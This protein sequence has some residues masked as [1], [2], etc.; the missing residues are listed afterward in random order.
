MLG[1]A[2]GREGLCLEDSAEL[3]PRATASRTE[4]GYRLIA[5]PTRRRNLFALRTT[6]GPW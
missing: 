2:L 3:V 5:A 4:P 6:H 1:T